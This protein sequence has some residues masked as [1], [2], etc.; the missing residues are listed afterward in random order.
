[1]GYFRVARNPSRVDAT[2]GDHF[3]Q[4]NFIS[5][6]LVI[7]PTTRELIRSANT[8]AFFIL[9]VDFECAPLALGG[10]KTIGR[11]LLRKPDAAHEIL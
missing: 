7:V 10:S 11:L 8:T 1:L 9:Y 6:N 2:R 3:R 5:T 4:A